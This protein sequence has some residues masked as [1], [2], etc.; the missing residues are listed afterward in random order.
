[1][2]LRCVGV[3]RYVALFPAC[4][5]C[6]PCANS[7]FR[8]YS[9]PKHGLPRD[10]NVTH[11]NRGTGRSKNSCQHARLELL[12]RVLTLSVFSDMKYYTAFRRSLLAASSGQSCTT[13]K[14]NYA[15][16]SEPLVPEHHSRWR[17]IPDGWNRHSC[18]IL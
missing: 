3:R 12:T 6:E 14:I 16:W 2:Y 8:L 4:R 7:N 13:L 18:K 10:M 5:P 15:T 1:M 9:K 17:Q 11:A